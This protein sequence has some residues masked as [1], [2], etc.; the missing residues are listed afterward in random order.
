[1]KSEK[2]A[3]YS[4]DVI[5]IGAGLCGLATALLL[6]EQGVSVHILEARGKTGGRVRSI[7]D[8]S[9]GE[10]LADLGPSWIWPDFQP[11][12][13]RWI[14]KLALKTLP[15]YDSGRA[16]I[17]YGPDHPS[18]ASFLPGQDGNHRVVGGS[19]AIVD[20][21]VDL[22]PSDAISLSTPANSISA[23]DEG[24][25]ISAGD[26]TFTARRLVVATPP[27]IA[28]QSIEWNQ[29]FPGDLENAL[30]MTPTWMAPHAKVVILYMEAF[31]RMQG[32]SGRIA[33]RF[34][35]I[36]ECHDHCSP[37]ETAAA[38]WGFIDWQHDVRVKLGE[39]LKTH[40]RLQLKRCFGPDSPEP[41]AIHIEEWS[42]DP[43]VAMSV[44]LAGPMHHPS[45]GP[46]ILRQSHFDGRVFFAGAET[47]KRSPGLIEGAFD[48]AERV[49]GA[50]TDK[51]LA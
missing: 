9:T 49:A 47:A 50:I 33:S 16:L 12:V 1:M 2:P 7:F 51:K 14:D 41:I 42:Q 21:L 11:V 26:D 34:G 19:Q 45:V 29:A 44:D 39:E 4:S 10:Y 38:L 25:T 20:A 28:L 8:E 22:L 13:K 27:R 30:N 32:L 37:D 17:D 24:V 43:Y 23:N 5:I 36:V 46:D 3:H 40:V 15:Q 31:W 18:R 48:A 6:H 35:P